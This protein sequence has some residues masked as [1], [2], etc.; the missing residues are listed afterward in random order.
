MPIDEKSSN[1]RTVPPTIYC[2]PLQVFSATINIDA[3][4]PSASQDFDDIID[5]RPG[6][7]GGGWHDLGSVNAVDEIGVITVASVG[8]VTGSDPTP[9]G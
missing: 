5:G 7:A 8:G 3:L 1:I 2:C 4:S 9:R 6:A